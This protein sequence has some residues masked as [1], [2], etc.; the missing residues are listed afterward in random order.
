M[1]H[2]T[3]KDIENLCGIKAHT[4]R[5]WEQRYKQLFCAKRKESKHRIYDDEDLKELL[6]ISYLYHQGYKISKIAELSP[7]DIQKMVECSCTREDNYEIFIHQL[8]EASV[9]FDKERFE[10][11][12]NSLVLRYGLDKCIIYVFFPFLQRIGLLWMTGHVIPA[13]EHFSSHIIRKKI[14]V[15]TD[16]LEQPS[17]LKTSILVF[18]PKGEFHEIP[19]LAAN[20]FFRKN[21]IQTVYFGVNVSL[22]T[23]CYYNKHQPV[24]HFYSHVITYLNNP[25]LEGFVCELC[26]RFPNKNIVFSG[27]ACKCMGEKRENLEFLKSFDDLL[28]FTKRVP[29]S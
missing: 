18:A 21:N 17:N 26:S 27:P 25:S 16:G 15:A 22:D 4:L 28:D 10:K 24:T 14:I 11:L 7:E 29:G 3:I 12:I 20:Y 5:I 9:D 2:F 13:Q 8:L 6:R 23:I 1:N 19:L